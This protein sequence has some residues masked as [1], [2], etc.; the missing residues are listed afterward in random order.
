MCRSPVAT[1]SIFKELKR[2]F[3]D[4]DLARALAAGTATDAAAGEEDG[5]P[6]SL[7]TSS[8]SGMSADD[9]IRGAISMLK[10]MPGI[11][12]NN[13]RRVMGAIYCV[14]DLAEMTQEQLTPLIGPVN[15]KKLFN[16]IRATF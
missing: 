3:E 7:V 16:F 1:T 11:D 15:S 13:V 9:A 5:A 4:V 14:A 2:N 10:K 8:S 6:D 12:E